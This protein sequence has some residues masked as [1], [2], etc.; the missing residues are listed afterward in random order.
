MGNFIAQKDGGPNTVQCNHAGP[1]GCGGPSVQQT[2]QGSNTVFV[3]GVGAVRK[4]DLMIPHATPTLNC[5][6]HAPP[7]N[8]FSGSVFIEGKNV[9]RLNDTYASPGT[10]VIN[11]VGQNSVWC[12]D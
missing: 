7:A 3:E 11:A 5:N 1:P 2:D 8:T 6:P 9:V 10:H 12:G 4:G